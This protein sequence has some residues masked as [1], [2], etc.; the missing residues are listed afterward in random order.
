M[1]R[2]CVRKYVIESFRGEYSDVMNEFKRHFSEVYKGE[3]FDVFDRKEGNVR[4]VLVKCSRIAD[5]ENGINFYRRLPSFEE[6][7]RYQDGL[8]ELLLNTDYSG[9]LA[10]AACDAKDYEKKKRI[11]EEFWNFIFNDG[12]VYFAPH[13]GKTRRKPDDIIPNP[14]GE[15]DMWSAG[16]SALAALKETRN[17]KEIHSIHTSSD[18]FKSYPAIIDIGDFGLLSS[19]EQMQFMKELNKINKRYSSRML[20]NRK[21]YIDKVYTATK[22]KVT[23][24]WDKRGTIDP[25]RLND[26]SKI[27]KFHI[28]GILKRLKDYNE[29]I[30]LLTPNYVLN[31]VYKAVKK[32]TPRIILNHIFTG[33][34]ISQLLHL[35][36]RN[37]NKA[38]QYECSEFY[39]EKDPDLVSDLIIEIAAI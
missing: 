21:E 16:V 34:K 9:E 33:R 32:D 2:D 5:E 29:S 35:E 15:N 11:Y 19:E 3:C 23:E 13:S 20:K 38:L 37:L 14:K 4:V 7:K 31:A 1:S 27:D 22:I 8:P 30:T 39:L 28:D 24:I 6:A 36:E 17:G 12:I 10:F 26:I 25:E 18:H